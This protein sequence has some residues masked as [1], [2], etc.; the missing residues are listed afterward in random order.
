MF[1]EKLKNL[2]GLEDGWSLQYTECWEHLGWECSG[3]HGTKVDV[4]VHV[5]IYTCVR[6]VWWGWWGGERAR[7]RETGR[8]FSLDELETGECAGKKGMRWSER[9]P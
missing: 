7:L 9:E 2:Q 3:E 6:E 1:L 5:H 4:C 8:D